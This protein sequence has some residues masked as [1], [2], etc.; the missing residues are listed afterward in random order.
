MTFPK[1]Q[2]AALEQHYDQRLEA[3]ESEGRNFDTAECMLSAGYQWGQSSL[4]DY[5]SF[6]RELFAHRGCADD[7][8]KAA[9]RDCISDNTSLEDWEIE[10]LMEELADEGINTAEDYLVWLEAAVRDS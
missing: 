9:L 8:V 4:P 1:L 7:S 3:A 6:Y 2:G 5:T 10:E